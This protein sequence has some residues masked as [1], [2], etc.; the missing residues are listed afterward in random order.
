MN[1]IDHSGHQLVVKYYMVQVTELSSH[2]H[3][4][5]VHFGLAHEMLVHIDVLYHSEHVVHR[6]MIKN[7]NTVDLCRYSCYLTVWSASETD[8]TM[9]MTLYTNW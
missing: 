8:A 2:A 3:V 9:S 1:W 7:V 4:R 5:C 6:C